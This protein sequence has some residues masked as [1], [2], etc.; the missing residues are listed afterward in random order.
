[1]GLKEEVVE[2]QEEIKPK[3]DI[4]GIETH[5][6]IDIVS[7]DKIMNTREVV[8]YLSTKP[9]VTLEYNRL[10]TKGCIKNP[11]A[12]EKELKRLGYYMG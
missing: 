9:D 1:M 11:N 4:S 2:E 6:P 3:K 10:K 8:G 5:R 7:N 12:T